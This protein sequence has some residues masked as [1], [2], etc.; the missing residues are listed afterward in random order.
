MRKVSD[1]KA[2]PD[3]LRNAT[4][5]SVFGLRNGIEAFGILRPL[6]L[7]ITTGN[8]VD[9]DK[10]LAALRD[11]GAEDVPCWCVE[12]SEEVED[13][14]HMALNNHVG[15]WVWQ[16]V[17]EQLKAIQAKGKP[18]TLTGFHPYDI[19]P[20]VAA[21]W[22]PVAVGKLEGGDPTQRDLL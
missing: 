2:H 4:S 18:L 10:V 3:T 11:A 5:E 12:L 8:I 19:G 1:L 6:V 13:V 20:L 9:G 17:S 15:E 22:T 7:N 21:D 16:S 14:A